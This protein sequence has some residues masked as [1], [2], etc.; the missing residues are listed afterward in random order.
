MSV[1]FISWSI[2]WLPWPAV[3]LLG[4]FPQ[5]G[6]AGDC[7]YRKDSLGNLRASDGTLCRSDSLGTLRCDGGRPPPAVFKSE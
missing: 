4:A 3:F 1:R 6:I 7:T 5:L 2:A